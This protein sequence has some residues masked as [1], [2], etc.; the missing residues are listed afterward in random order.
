VAV[1]GHAVHPCGSDADE[2]PLGTVAVAPV[3]AAS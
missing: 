1:A 2:T 3:S